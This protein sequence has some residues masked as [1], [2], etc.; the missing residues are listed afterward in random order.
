MPLT[1]MCTSGSDVRPKPYRERDVAAPGGR[2]RRAL[3]AVAHIR[4]SDA[5]R[6]ARSL[7]LL[8]GLAQSV[9]LI[10]VGASY[11]HSASAADPAASTL[12][13]HAP[14]LHAHGWVLLALGLTNI[15]GFAVVHQC[16]TRTG[17][18][19][20]RWSSIAA[21]LYTIYCA[22]AF[23]YGWVQ[24][25]VMDDHAWWYG[26]LVVL[27]LIVLVLP[28]PVCEQHQHHEDLTADDSDCGA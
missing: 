19:V 13:G 10:V 18:V 20:H 7:W 16:L 26:L 25:G 6:T 15:W 4:D 27:S 8:I 9:T 14:G 17:W 3:N 5:V 22:Y 21:S 24:T 2:V 28:P 12:L 23:A 11:A 1:T